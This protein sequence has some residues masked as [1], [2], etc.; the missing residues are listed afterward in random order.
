MLSRKMKILTFLSRL[1][2]LEYIPVILHS[3]SDY[4]DT[5]IP[6]F[7]PPETARLPNMMRSYYPSM[8][9]EQINVKCNEIFLKLKLKQQDIDDV[10]SLTRK[11]STCLIWHHVRCERITA[12][13]VYDVLHTDINNTS[14]LLIESICKEPGFQIECSVLILSMSLSIGP[15]KLIICVSLF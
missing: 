6:K 13:K 3:Y 10:E 5:F 8:H 14:T 11:Q 1:S 4:C 7:K 15:C 2:K 9:K 12:S